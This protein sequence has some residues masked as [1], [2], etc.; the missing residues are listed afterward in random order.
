MISTS[1]KQEHQAV[2]ILGHFI[3]NPSIQR[4]YSKSAIGLRLGGVGL[5]GGLAGW[6]VD[7]WPACTEE[8][9]ISS[10][11]STMTRPL[12]V[13]SVRRLTSR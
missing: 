13:I 8:A 7:A 1:S 4:I 10:S 9:D 3:L 6:E 5:A 11:C 12:A 2:V